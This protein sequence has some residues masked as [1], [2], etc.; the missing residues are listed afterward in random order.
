VT[1]R[2]ANAASSPAWASGTARWVNWWIVPNR[3]A[4]LAIIVSAGLLLFVAA[5]WPRLTV[6]A[7]LLTLVVIGIALRNT[8]PGAREPGRRGIWRR[9]AGIAIALALMLWA[10]LSLRRG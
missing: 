6:P 1:F 2:K 3:K 10:F 7:C 8:I 4:Q 5:Q 9:A